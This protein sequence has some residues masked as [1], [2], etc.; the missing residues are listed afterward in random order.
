MIWLTALAAFNIAF[1]YVWCILSF[2]A[3]ARRDCGIDW[4][5]EA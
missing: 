2:K 5:F 4:S 1:V 3:N